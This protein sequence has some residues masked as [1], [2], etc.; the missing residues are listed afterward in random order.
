MTAGDA[1]ASDVVQSRLSTMGIAAAA[2]KLRPGVMCTISISV[3][4]RV[5]HHRT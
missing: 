3:R 2:L 5:A 1:A 4:V